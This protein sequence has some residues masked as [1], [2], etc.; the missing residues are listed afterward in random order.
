VTLATSPAIV[1]WAA[2]GA[3]SAWRWG[4]LA[5]IAAVLVVVAAI[6]TAGD[7]WMDWIR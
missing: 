4:G 7:A 2:I 5:R 6:V 1:I 3:V